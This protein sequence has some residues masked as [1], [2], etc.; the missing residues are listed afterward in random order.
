MK[1]VGGENG[2]HWGPPRIARGKLT[3]TYVKI[4]PVS[5]RG[6]GNSG[7]DG[8]DRLNVMP[9]LN[10]TLRSRFCGV[11]VLRGLKYYGR[12]FGGGSRL[13]ES[14][15][16]VTKSILWVRYTMSGIILIVSSLFR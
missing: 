8:S 5:L 14:K 11:R 7:A 10:A 4:P 2:S 3:T 15:Y 13:A 9:R 1:R 6:G 12:D 16:I